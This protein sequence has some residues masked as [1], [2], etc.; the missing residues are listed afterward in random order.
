MSTVKVLIF[1][2][3]E[4]QYFT[5]KADESVSSGDIIIVPFGRQKK[6]LGL[7]IEPDLEPNYPRL[8]SIESKII[9]LGRE[10]VELLKKSANYYRV[11]EST[12]L[13]AMLP[14]DFKTQSEKYPARK[15]KYPS[16]P[17]VSSDKPLTLNPGQEQAVNEILGTQKGSSILLHGVTGSG[18]TEVYLQAI[19]RYRQTSSKPV[20]VLVPEIGLT[21]QITHRF[22]QRFGSDQVLVYHSGLTTATR[23]NTWRAI[24]EGTASI[25]IGTRSAVFAPLKEIGLIIIDEEHDDSFKQQEPIP[26]YD[27]R[28]VAQ[29]R[30]Q[31]CGCPLVLGTATPSIS[32][33]VNPDKTYI[34]LKH[35][36][37]TLMPKIELVDMR[38]ELRQG[39]YSVFSRQLQKQ[40]QSLQGKAILFIHRRGHSTFV[41]CRS[42]GSVLN[43]P[44]C[45]VSLKYHQNDHR[46]HCHYCGHKKILPPR[47]P[48]CDSTAFK[49]FGAGTQKVEAELNSLFPEL[50]FLRF[51]SDTVKNHQHE[52]IIEEFKSDCQVLIGTQILAKGLDIPSVDLVGIISADGLLHFSDYNAYERAFQTLT[53]VA[54]R[55]GRGGKQGTVV[56]Q[57]YTPEHPVIQAI[58]NYGYESFVE[59]ELT[60]REK[61]FYPPYCRIVLI[62]L[63]GHDSAQVQTTAEEIATQLTDILDVDADVLGPA[64][65][66]IQRINERFYWQIIL[67]LP[68]DFD[69]NLIPHFPSTD[70]VRITMNIDA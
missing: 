70:A 28:L 69:L 47:C 22:R 24:A 27:A 20:L 66:V 33:W 44:R 55:C 5:Y 2:F 38:E 51:D 59:T 16:Q 23:Y 10:F 25:I 4:N 29:W 53:Q 58:G 21:P 67:K 30:S 36:I 34:E 19:A 1:D 40:L 48:D 64:P 6:V 65:T 31:F 60:Q 61:L 9:P 35:R 56:L 18:K 46:V 50:K 68:L 26:C 3:P 32:T 7:V 15:K 49:F 12:M 14:P 41:S 39:N 57:T 62:R 37:Q 17:E 8:K 43:C 11:P 54:G 13:R 63:S 52:Q 45:D 42:C